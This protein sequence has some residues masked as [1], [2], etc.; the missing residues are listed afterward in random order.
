MVT[1]V[2]AHLASHG[3]HREGDELAALGGIET[4]RGPCESRVGDLSQIL[5]GD[6]SARVARDHGIGQRHVQDDDL[7]EQATPL[8]G[9]V[10]REHATEQL[11]GAPCSRL[12]AVPALNCHQ[13]RHV[14]AFGCL[15]CRLGS[16]A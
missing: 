11:V 13:G 6:P 1:E 16:T 7:V 10:G 12:P 8:L 15:A 5:P 3:R 2:L 14:S 4:V 9:V